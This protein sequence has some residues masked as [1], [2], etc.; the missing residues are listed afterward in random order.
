MKLA[1]VSSFNELL[2]NILIEELSRHKIDAYFISPGS[3]STPLTSTVAHNS[4]LKTYIHY[5]ERG[6]AFQALG[7]AKATQKPGV[8]ICTSGSAATNYYPAI[9]EASADNI[10]MVVLT[11]DR[12]PELHNVLANQT[13]NQQNLFGTHVRAFYNIEPP[14]KHSSFKIILQNFSTT[15][16]KVVANPKGPIHINCM[17]CEP[18]VHA[19][20]KKDFSQYILEIKDWIESDKPYAKINKSRTIHKPDIGF[21]K[22]ISTILIAGAMQIKKESKAVLDFAERFNLPLFADIRSGLRLSKK[23]EN[24][25]S[26]YDQMLTAKMLQTD[27][28]YQ[29]IHVGGNIVSKRLMQF[30]EKSNIKT[31][32]V[33]HNS[34]NAYN[35]HH[36]LTHSSNG[37]LIKLL[38][39]MADKL[40]P[41]DKTFLKQMQDC[42]KKIKKTLAAYSYNFSEISIARILSQQVA[43]NSFIYSANSL[44][45]RLM[46]M[47]AEP[48][49]MNCTII[50]NRGLSG[51]DGTIASAVGYAN[52]AKKSG[53]LLIGDLAFQHDLNSLSLLEKSEYP[54]VLVILNNNGGKIFSSLP[55]AKDTK[56]FNAYFETPQN[57]T[58][59][60]IAKQY[61][62]PYYFISSSRQFSEVFNKAQK[63]KKS[64]I[65]EIGLQDSEIK[66]EQNKIQATIKKLQ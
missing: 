62:L 41:F 45:I 6:A 61:S 48:S 24:L 20:R 5:D 22:K 39:Q 64:V 54:I 46:D 30:I 21:D 65:I 43:K 52:G 42:N 26:Y 51:I 34:K 35:P 57:M 14:T 15:I 47:F 1:K 2:V 50:A 29:I 56:I 27:R 31:Y 49:E 16:S 13:F 17:F 59:E 63:T 37:E 18:L 66:Q 53:T 58:F 3:R 10:P 25:I 32:Y 36:K 44:S 33:L 55:I 60:S 19:K 12:P 4:H 38:Q 28:Q 7:Y 9:A 40:Q 23:S 11:A 8:L